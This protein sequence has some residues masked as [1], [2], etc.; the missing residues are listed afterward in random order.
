MVV[1]DRGC[2][3]WGC[4]E[5]INQY[6]TT[7]EGCTD[8]I[9]RDYYIESVLRV[10]Q[11]IQLLES[12]EAHL[13]E[14]DTSEQSRRLSSQV[15]Y[16]LAQ[17]MQRMRADLDCSD[18]SSTRTREE[19]KNLKNSLLV[20]YRYGS[21]VMEN[22]RCM[23]MN[24]YFDRSVECPAHL[25]KASTR[26]VGLTEFHL[27]ASNVNDERNSLLLFESVESAFDS[28]KVCL[29]YDPFGGMLRMKILCADVK[30]LFGVGDEQL[31]ENSMK[32][33]SLATLTMPFL[34]HPMAFILIDVC[35]IGLVDVHATQKNWETGLVRM[36]IQKTF[37]I[38]QI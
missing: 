1:K 17:N 5:S 32:P 16:L 10:G 15:K 4:K 12:S 19:E 7:I 31:R 34:C 29:M 20:I 25:W 35:L 14:S 9:L 11:Q 33:E 30:T 37:S 38:Y 26:D 2:L 22:I 13:I 27:Q 36:K 3:T 21:P 8:P 23:V 28:K 6:E 18:S 24:K